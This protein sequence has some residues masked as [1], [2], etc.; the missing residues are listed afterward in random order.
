MTWITVFPD[1]LAACGAATEVYLRPILNAAG[2]TLGYTP[3]IR[4]AHPH[5]GRAAV[6]LAREM[7]RRLDADEFKWSHRGRDSNVE[8]HWP[9]RTIQEG[10]NWG[11]GTWLARTFC[12]QSPLPV[13]KQ[14]FEGRTWRGWP[15]VQPDLSINDILQGAA[16]LAADLATLQTA[17]AALD[18]TLAAECAATLAASRAA[19]VAELGARSPGR[20]A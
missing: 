13:S 7:V 18:P 8:S 10:G 16:V 17:S 9:Y 6:L 3:A 5:R 19:F 12:E 1:L 11:D 14:R 20:F 2:Y 4:S 15:A